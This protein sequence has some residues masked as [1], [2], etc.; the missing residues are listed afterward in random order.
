MDTKGK[1]LVSAQE[2]EALIEGWG[3]S[4]TR[5]VDCYYP[6][7][8][9]FLILVVG[10]HGLWLLFFPA[11]IAGQ[12]SPDPSV[13]DY[14]T[15]YLYVRGWYMLI[16]LGF[17]LTYVRGWYVG[18][19]FSALTLLGIVNLMLDLFSLYPYRLSEPNAQ[20]TVLMGI[21][22]L[23]LACVFLN[24]RN[25]GRLPERKDRLN[26]LLFRRRADVA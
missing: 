16:I 12:L 15:G 5:R 20:F 6:L 4:R 25:A 22:L 9:W 3:T 23:A 13:A 10:L 18:I 14:L 24:A 19:V 26:V 7:R 8:S 1:P 2:L 11:Q 17:I 21:R